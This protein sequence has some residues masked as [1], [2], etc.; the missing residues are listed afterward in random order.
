[1]DNPVESVHLDLERAPAAQLRIRY[2]F[3]SELIRM[4]VLP[5]PYE[6]RPWER[7]ERAE[8]FAYCPDP[9]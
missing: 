3:R 9:H 5:P 7:R 1:V 8:G 6:P 2:E 4:G